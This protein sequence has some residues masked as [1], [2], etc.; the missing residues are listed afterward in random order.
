MV[1]VLSVLSLATKQV[2]EGR[3]SMTFHPLNIYPVSDHVPGKYVKKLMGESE[4][5]AALQRLDRLTIDEARMTGTETLQ[6][7]H[8]LVSNLK[9][10]MDST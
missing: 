7:V 2:K 5:D 8:S 10:V 3:F 6:V 4:I 1:E 9:L